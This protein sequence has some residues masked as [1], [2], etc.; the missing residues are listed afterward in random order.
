MKTSV[1]GRK[2]WQRGSALP[3]ILALTIGV[4]AL[5]AGYVMRNLREH[6]RESFD[7]DNEKSLYDAWSQME[8]V[9]RMVNTAGYDA[10]GKNTALAA[11]LARPDAQFIDNDG[12]PTNVTV[13]ANGGAGAGFYDIVSTATVGGATTRVTAL[14][15]ERQSFA[16][17]NYFVASNSLGISGGQVSTFPY[18]DAPE[19]SIHSNDKLMFYFP[20]RHFRDAVSAVNGFQY[21]AGARGPG[22]PSGQNNW[23]HGSMS[24]ASSPINGLTDVDIPGFTARTD[25]ILSLTGDWDFAKVHLRGTTA[26]VEHWQKSH[27]EMQTVMVPTQMFH[28]ETQT[29]TVSDY[30]YVNQLVPVTTPVYGPV[31]VPV[32]TATLHHDLVSAQWVETIKHPHMVSQLVTAAWDETVT[33]T[34]NVAT[35]VWVAGG[36]GGDTG[37]SGGSGGVGYWTTVMVPTTTTSIVHHN[38]VYTQVQQGW[39]A[40]TYV[41]HPAVYNDWYSYTQTG[42]QVVTQQIGTQ[43]NMVMT[44]V[45]QVVGSH[46]V[47]VQVQVS[48]GWVNVPTQQSVFVPQHKVQDYTLPTQGTVYVKGDTYF[49]PMSTGT[50]GYDVHTMNGS[51]TF[52][53]DGYAYIQD[54]IVYA[55]PDASNVMQTAYLNGADHTQEYKPNPNYHGQSVLG[56]VANYDIVYRSNLPTEAEI[57]ATLLTKSGEVRVDGVSVN[58][59]GTVSQTSGGWVKMSLRRL[60]GMTT[61]LRP[62]ST[63]VDSS[64]AVTRGFVYSKSVYDVRQRTTP[65]RGFPTLNRPRVL[66]TILKEV[67]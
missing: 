42:T 5:T 16:D 56:I 61:N 57:N 21:T 15:R 35:Q 12:W 20:D 58:S 62:V 37:G 63:Y 29:Q 24:D 36:G 27:N 14:C 51:M 44:P 32:Y 25:N 53:T 18:S 52:A 49:V 2:R 9:S 1:S 47:Q 4:G 28:T 26:L 66:A 30:G 31:T 23:F 6:G 46:Q 39:D 54:S 19:G 65:P 13:A 67:K 7:R 45:W 38:A 48:D 34:T 41:T 8:V 59:A 17:F 60:G 10:A 11:A 33:T 22:D 43:T 3:A 64:N 40:D 55:A 50:D